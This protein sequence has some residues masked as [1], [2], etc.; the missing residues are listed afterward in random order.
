M[1]RL[2]IKRDRLKGMDARARRLLS[3]VVRKAAADVEAGAKV[4]APVDTGALRNSIQ[5]QEVSP[6]VSQVAVGVEY[7][8]YVEYG[9]H[10]ASA[11]PYLNPAVEQV[12]PGFLAAVGR[13]I[14][15][16]AK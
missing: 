12:Q 3:A 14:E 13:A 5:A 9:T 7:G 16:A 11:Q 2:E 6:L 15:E 10:K 4:R 1:V 8:V